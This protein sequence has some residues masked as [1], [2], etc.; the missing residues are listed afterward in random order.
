M[1][2]NLDESESIK[3]AS[4]SEISKS[5]SDRWVEREKKYIEVLY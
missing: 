1:R 2:W 4:N 3:A 5:Y